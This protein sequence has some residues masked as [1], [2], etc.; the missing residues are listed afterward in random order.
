MV[1]PTPSMLH[2]GNYSMLNPHHTWRRPRCYHGDLGN[3]PFLCVVARY[4]KNAPLCHC[5]RDRA[6][7]TQCSRDLCEPNCVS[8]TTSASV[9]RSYH[10]L[11]AP[12]TCAQ[13]NHQ[14]S[15]WDL[16]A[17]LLWLDCTTLLGCSL[18]VYCAHAASVPRSY[19]DHRCYAVYMAPFHGKLECSV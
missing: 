4:Q 13:C 1:D 15:E 18:C 2:H 6:V 14:R 8:T 11:T 16:T 3:A 5:N 12:K 7:L 17:M 19:G 9:R 10:G